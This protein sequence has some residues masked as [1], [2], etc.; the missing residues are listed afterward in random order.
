MR[1]RPTAFLAGI[2][3]LSFS[4]T[5]NA[6]VLGTPLTSPSTKAYNNSAV[7]VYGQ[8]QAELADY[9]DETPHNTG[10]KGLYLEDSSRGRLGIKTVENLDNGMK[11]FLKYELRADTTDTSA[12][13]TRDALIGIN[14]DFG[15]ISAGRLKSPYKYTGGVTYDVFNDTTLEATGHGGMSPSEYGHDDFISNALAWRSNNLGGL[16]LKLLYAPE[17]NDGL[18]SGSIK[19]N[20]ANFE[21]FA[22]AIDD[23]IRLIN[24]SLPNDKSGYIAQKY[25][26]S[27]SQG[28]HT[29]RAQYELI[30]QKDA[31]GSKTEPKVFFLGYTFAQEQTAYTLQYGSTD[32]DQAGVDDTTY[33][34]VGITHK[35]S[36][37]TRVFGGYRSTTDQE[38]VFSVGMRMDFSTN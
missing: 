38:S 30:E 17:V 26:G 34:A 12:L 4:S 24:P 37:S 3:I 11:V 9:S 20:K 21:I 35:Y 18:T 22:T 10:N 15:S 7:V 27:Y 16:Q 25:G 36:R 28:G 32:H 23:G 1:I 2:A 29:I 19:Y 6:A 8:I 14:G 33:A 31:G 13:T 5:T